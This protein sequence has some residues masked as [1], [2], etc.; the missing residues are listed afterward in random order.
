MAKAV[1]KFC[2]YAVYKFLWLT[3]FISFCGCAVYKFL[4]LT[5]FISFCGCA[6]YKF[7]FVEGFAV[8]W[9]RRLYVYWTN[10]IVNCTLSIIHYQLSI[11]HYYSSGANIG[12]HGGRTIGFWSSTFLTSP[13][14]Y[15]LFTTIRNIYSLNHSSVK[16]R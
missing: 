13:L 4:W 11:V 3:P 10:L 2:G 7:N 16:V 15:F 6:V 8:L 1:Y 12:S 9:L 14:K 5:P